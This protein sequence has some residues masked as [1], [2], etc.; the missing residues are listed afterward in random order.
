METSVRFTPLSGV[1]AESPLCYLLEI[2]SFTILLDCG[3]DENFDLDAL[4]PIKRVLPRVNAVLISHPDLAHLGALPYLVGKCGLRAPIYSTKPVR[5]MGEMFMFESYLAKQAV[6]DFETFDLDDVDAAFRLNARWRELQFSQRHQLVPPPPPPPPGGDDDDDDDAAGG[7]SESSVAAAGGGIEIVA[8][9]AG[10]YPGGSV[11]RISLGCGE[12]VVYAVD[13]N[14]RKERLLNRTHFDE[15]LAAVQPA[16]LVTDAFNALTENTDRHRRDEEFLGAITATVEAEGSVLIPTD[17][18][19]RVLELALLLD[20]HFSKARIAAVPVL[21]SATIKTVLEFARTQ[22]EY[23]GNELVQ[24][25]SL[26]RAVPFSFRKL[27]VIT[28]LEELGAFPGPKV[29]LATM[30]SLEG[31]PARELLVQWASLPRNTILFTERAQAGTL[32]A[33]LQTHDPSVAAGPLRLQLRM[34]RRVPLEGEELAEW[35]AAKVAAAQ[36]LAEHGG[37][38]KDSLPLLSPS[39]HLTPAVRLA[40]AVRLANAGSGPT[41]QPL[42][43]STGSISRLVRDST[44]GAIVQ[45]LT[46]STPG[47]PGAGGGARKHHGGGG[48]GWDAGLLMDGFEPPTDAAFPMFPD[49]DEPLYCEWDE[50]GAVLGKDEFRVPTLTDGAGAAAGRVGA[51]GEGMDVD[52]GDIAGGGGRGSGGGGGDSGGGAAGAS[53]DDADVADEVDE[54]P[55]KLVL[56]EIDLEVHAAIRYFDFEGRSD[57]KSAVEYLARVAPRRF[58]IVHGS[59]AARAAMAA[60]LRRELTYYGTQ[61]FTPELGESLEA[62]LGASQVAALAPTLAESLAVRQAGQY[63]VAWL[64]GRVTA[65]EAA[66]TAGHGAQIRVLEALPADDEGLSG[67]AAAEATARLSCGRGAGAGSV[68]LAQAGAVLTLTRLKAALLAAGFESH[69]PSRGVLAV[70]VGDGPSAATLIVTLG[71]GTP[72]DDRVVHVS[73]DGPASEAYYKVREVIYEQF[74]VC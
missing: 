36:E 57:G 40:A 72:A 68:L 73:L 30:P 44:T 18:A 16:L 38:V 27:S 12:E 59:T 3:W 56:S 64:E 54:A 69:F 24:A 10:R 52:V 41:D 47:G 66:A 35:Q 45:T 9:P 5:R 33:A 29:V 23:L 22:L 15:L 39:G 43:A 65:G 20:E 32:A 62:R 53:G 7:S 60:A 71:S 67:A 31:G 8:H 51:G 37:S 25:F 74:G 63:G 6:S 42:R 4:E 70:M 58:A 48:G 19:G 1:D 11:W 49:E 34:G 46:A 61:V 14:H 2:D 17:A 50:Y 26:K 21:L 28:R 55:T 13:Y